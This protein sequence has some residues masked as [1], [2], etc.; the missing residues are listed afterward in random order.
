MRTVSFDGFCDI[1]K[2]DRKAAIGQRRAYQD[3]N[4]I[5]TN[6]TNRIDHHLIFS[7]ISISSLFNIKSVFEIGT[8]AGN[9]CRVL[10][11]VFPD[12]K[13]KTLDLEEGHGND[14][15]A[16]RLLGP[17][18][19]V[20]MLYYDSLLLKDKE[21]TKHDCIFV[22]GCHHNP[23]ANSDIA[24]AYEYVNKIIVFHDVAKNKATDVLECLEELQPKIQ[25]EILIVSSGNSNM[26]DIGVLIKGELK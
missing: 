1:I 10:A 6:I 15:N 25:E 11:S 13:I 22:D 8:C 23:V 5:G 17:L 21:R 2:V 3:F 9:C 26:S 20:E 19:N 14:E 4:Y 7:A 24:W 16:K 12:A 18:D